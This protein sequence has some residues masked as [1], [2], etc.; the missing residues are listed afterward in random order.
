MGAKKDKRDFSQQISITCYGNQLE[1][2]ILPL[3]LDTVF[4]ITSFW[5]YQGILKDRLI[6][7]NIGDQFPYT[8]PQSANSYG[9]KKGYVCL[10]DLR[11]QTDEIIQEA[12]MKFYFLNPYHNKNISV[13]LILSPE[14]Y[15][16]LI[17]YTVAKREVGYKE[18]WIPYVECWYPTDIP[19][20]RVEKIINV[21]VTSEANNFSSLS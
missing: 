11:S 20:E 12:L 4:H 21:T 1:E 10:F 15:A 5:G 8:F 18:M 14:L 7:P 3:L 16:D 6:K 17:D 13:Y 2:K 19:L 9:L